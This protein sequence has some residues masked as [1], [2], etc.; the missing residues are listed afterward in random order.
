MDDD[1][2][3]GDNDDD[4]EEEEEEEERRKQNLAPPLPGRT[5]QYHLVRIF[6][7]LS[8]GSNCSIKV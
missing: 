3:D 6:A 4:E 8:F 2:N 1:D 5:L 7:Q